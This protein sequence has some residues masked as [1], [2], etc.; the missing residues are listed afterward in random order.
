VPLPPGYFLIRCFPTREYRAGEFDLHLPATSTILQLRDAIFTRLSAANPSLSL[1]TM[2]LV[3]NGKK[4]L[5]PTLV[6][7]TFGF[8][9]GDCVAIRRN[10]DLFTSYLP[11]PLVSTLALLCQVWCVLAFW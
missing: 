2:L 4:L 9:S 11:N 3:W 5:T 7:D 10:S 6:L 1:K 8:Q